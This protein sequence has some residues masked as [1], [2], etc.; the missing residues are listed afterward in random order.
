FHAMSDGNEFGILVDD[1][2]VKLSPPVDV[3]V[4]GITVPSLNCPTSNVFVQATVT[5]YNTTTINFATYPVTV[6]ANITGAA[7]GTL[8]ALLNTGTL[9]AGA[10]TNVYLS[11]SFN[12]TTSGLYNITVATSTS[13]ASNDP[14]TGNDSYS[15]SI[16]VNANPP[17]PV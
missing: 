6:T 13:P 10:S 5:N 15:T 14:E 4:S 8:T 12:F 7:T 17:V 1:I 16:N 9:A 2:S 11:P 3:G